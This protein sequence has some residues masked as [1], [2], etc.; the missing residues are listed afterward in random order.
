MA[1]DKQTEEI[2]LDVIENDDF[3]SLKPLLNQGLNIDDK[4]ADG[5]T[6]LHKCFALRKYNITQ[7]LVLLGADIF[8]RNNLNRTPLHIGT[9]SGFI[10][11]TH[12][13]T[14]LA[15]DLNQQDHKGRIP[16]MH[17][18]KFKQMLL[19]KVLMAK[20]SDTDLK[21]NNGYSSLMW[22]VK[23]LDPAELKE[24][25]ENSNDEEIQNQIQ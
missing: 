7:H 1:I 23:Y 14:L 19:V 22:A 15:N 3:S 2:L 13:Y 9:R 21:D 17:A 16:L 20:G 8:S 6:I 11:G 12:L 5:E 18:I 24:L 4:F 25:M 10:E